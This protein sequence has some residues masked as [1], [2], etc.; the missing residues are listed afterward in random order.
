MENEPSAS[1]SSPH[2][3]KRSVNRRAFLLSAGLA[4][5]AAAGNAKAETPAAQPTIPGDHPVKATE[6]GQFKEALRKLASDTS[7]RNEASTNPKLITEKFKLSMQD[8]RSLRDAA[9]LSGVD[10]KDVDALFSKAENQPIAAA[11]ACCC[12]C[13]CCGD[14]GVAIMI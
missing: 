1:Q 12:C 13:C 14:T 4:G 6:G 2:E 9:V 7:F 3:P 11:Q 10:I 5:A 8:L